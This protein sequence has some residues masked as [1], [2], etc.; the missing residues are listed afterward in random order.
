M[1]TPP[2]PAADAAKS[3]GLPPATRTRNAAANR[4][5]DSSEAEFNDSGPRL[6][7]ISEHS[8]PL[9]L[10]KIPLEVQEK[11]ARLAAEIEGEQGG[12]GK[13]GYTTKGGSRKGGGKDNGG[14][15]SGGKDYGDR[16]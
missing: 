7:D 1:P 11:A 13:K 9:D 8:T 5:A 10:S 4:W 16:K 15:Y 2:P 14:G 12:G 3:N 6:D